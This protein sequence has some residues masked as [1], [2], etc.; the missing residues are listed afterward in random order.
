[1]AEG[2]AREGF[3]S[4]NLDHNGA[5]NKNSYFPMSDASK[6]AFRENEEEYKRGKTDFLRAARENRRRRDLSR[7][8]FSRR[9]SPIRLYRNSR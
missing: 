3:A 8:K 4:S 5:Q 7:S 1:M 6:S 9:P 2:G